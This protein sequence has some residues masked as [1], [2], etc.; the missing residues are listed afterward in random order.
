MKG[1]PIDTSRRFV[2]LWLVACLALYACSPAPEEK[3]SGTGSINL[4][5]VIDGLRPDYITPE[6]M[7]NL[8]ALGGRG[9]IG[10]RHT[11]AFPTVTRVNSASISTGSYPDRHGLVH[12]TMYIAELPGEAFS[13]G[14]AA[15]LDRMAQF[16]GGSLLG[17]PSLAEL[18]DEHG[19]SL[20]VTGSAGSGTTLLQNPRRNARTWSAGGLFIPENDRG[21]AIAAVGE[22]AGSN[23]GRTVWAVDAYL[24]A[25]S[26]NDPPNAAIIWINEPDSAGHRHG[27]G[28]PGTLRVVGNVDAQIGRIVAAHAEHDLTDRVNIFVTTDHGFSDR[29]GGFDV[30]RTLDSARIRDDDV[31][32]VGNMVFLARDDSALL[33]NVVEALQRDPEIGNVYTRPARPGSSEGSAPGTL[34][35]AV[36]QWDHPRAADV[37][38]SPSWSDE[39][40]EFGFAGT[41]TREGSGGS[42]GSDSPYDLRIRLIAAGP[43]LKRGVRSRVPTGNVDLAPTVLY[44]LGIEPP[45]AMSGRVLHELLREGPSPDETPVHE[46]LHK[47][48]VAFSDGS[49]YEAELDTLQVGST[50]YVRGARTVRRVVS[51]TAAP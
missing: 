29:A 4:L 38:A 27:V 36:I 13:T 14:S 42:H 48:A 49:R 30:A 44:L 47:A 8:H 32:V 18:L 37:L 31:T 46:H 11:A 34:S 21:R 2:I 15:A 35:T 3:L 17:A 10:E 28:A 33:A 40:N 6:L 5:I 1:I 45:P 24:H 39:V 9:V 43:D 50:V 7:P 19:L 26:R 16:E 12:N 20:F 22:L 51:T 41:T 23:A 25:V